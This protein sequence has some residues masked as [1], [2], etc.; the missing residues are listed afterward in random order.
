VLSI[1]STLCNLQAEEGVYAR[2]LSWARRYPELLL[3]CPSAREVKGMNALLP[4]RCLYLPNTYA[5]RTEEQAVL[6]NIEMRFRRVRRRVSIFCAYRPLKNMATQIAAVALA[7][8]EI[9]L[10]LHLLE[11][12]GNNPLYRSVQALTEGLPFPVVYHASMTNEACRRLAGE[13]DLGLQVSLSETFSYVACEHMMGGVPV[14]GSSSVPY[15]TLIAD[16][17]DVTD[18]AAKIVTALYDD[19]QYRAFALDSRL[20]AVRLAEKNAA[21]ALA[22]I[23]KIQQAGKGG[24]LNDDD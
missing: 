15:A 13:M 6:S 1:H 22:A 19:E 10:E 20:R 14:V 16:Y 11:G 12:P 7:A 18:I 8:R 17:S 3:T 23:E 9:P 2:L 21:D 24:L 5:C 4:I